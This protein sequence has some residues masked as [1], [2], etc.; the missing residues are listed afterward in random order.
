MSAPADELVRPLSP[1][2][3]LLAMCSMVRYRFFL[4]AGSAA[5]RPRSGVGVCDRPAR[6]M[7]RIFWSGLAGVVLAVI[8]VEAF[9]EYF[10]SRMGT[11]RVFNPADLPPMSSVVM[12]L[13]IVAFAGALAVGD[14]PR[15]PG[16]L[17]DSCFRLAGRHGRDLLCRTADPLGLSRPGRA[18]H[19]VVV[20]AVDGARQ[21][22]ICTPARCRGGALLA[23]LVPG[24]P[25]HGAR[26]RERDPRLPSGPPGGQAQSRGQG[27]A[28]ASSRPL[29]RS[30]DG[31]AA[32][33]SRGRRRRACFPWRAS[34]RFSPCRCSC[35]AR[36]R[37]GRSFES[38]RLFV[39]AIRS[40]VRVLSRSR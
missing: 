35:R 40:I 3:R 15:G 29:C 19:R 23:S 26:G 28:P 17:A 10:D 2:H 31:G 6:W 38:P 8:G 37:R 14:L 12:W 16:R 20:R 13:G 32:G 39:P 30:R 5:V 25:H 18:R 27:G 22:R 9:N 7:G 33:R 1:V 11:D 24:F 36:A 34:L 21:R 4:Y